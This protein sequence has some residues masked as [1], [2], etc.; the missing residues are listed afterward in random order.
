MVIQLKKEAFDTYILQILFFFLLIITGYRNEMNQI[1]KTKT[2][3]QTPWQHIVLSTLNNTHMTHFLL[4]M[5]I[6]KVCVC[7][8]ENIFFLLDKRGQKKKKHIFL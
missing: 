8:A 7:S 1:C 4:S 5:T 2:Q 6:F 3:D